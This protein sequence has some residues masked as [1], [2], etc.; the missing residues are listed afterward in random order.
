MIDMNI[1]IEN[2][3]L[4][5][6]I[7]SVEGINIHVGILDKNKRAKVANRNK[8]PLKKVGNTGKSAS[9]VKKDAE[10]TLG[11]LAIYLDERYGVFTDAITRGDNHQLNIVTQ[12]LISAFSTGTVN[13]RRIENAAIMF[14]KN[15]I[16]RKEFGS[17]SKVTIGGGVGYN[18]YEVDGKGFDWPMVD[19]GTFF[20]NI[21]AEI[22]NV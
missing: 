13:R 17:N 15:P 8:E 19:T 16:Q 4:D 1:N 21:N 22:K 10:I 3:F 18:G 14:I 5:A 20:T 7:K 12:E 6:H 9:Y 11:E 2:D